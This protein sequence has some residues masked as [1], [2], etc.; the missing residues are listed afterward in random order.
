MSQAT[1]KLYACLGQTGILNKIGAMEICC[2][3]RFKNVNLF[4]A[5]E[6]K[7]IITSAA[8]LLVIANTNITIY[9]KL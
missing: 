6:A 2:L 4:L 5:L 8:H 7:E 1:R 9:Q 3:N